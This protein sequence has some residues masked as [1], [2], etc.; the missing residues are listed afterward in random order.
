MFAWRS[1][2]TCCGFDSGRLA[3]H[4]ICSFSVLWVWSMNERNP[5]QNS[6]T[7]T[8]NG[9][10]QRMPQGCLSSWSS[11]L[12]FIPSLPILI[13]QIMFQNVF[14]YITMVAEIGQP[15]WF[16]LD[17]I[18]DNNNPPISIHLYKPSYYFE[19]IWFNWAVFKNHLLFHIQSGLVKNGI[20]G[21]LGFLESPSHVG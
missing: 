16:D 21:T 14:G 20:P 8:R 9:R 12:G 18:L 17:P 2:E 6:T 3:F 7:W 11:R 5:S 19:Q 10:H 4:R 15:V 13:G 1:H